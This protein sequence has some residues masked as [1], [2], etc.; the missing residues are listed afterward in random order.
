MADVDT[1]MNVG[2]TLVIPGETCDPDSTTCVLTN[3]SAINTCVMGGPRLYYTIKG[4]TYE[5]IALR[6]NL[7]VDTVADGANATAPLTVGEFVKLP[8]CGPSQCVIQ[9]YKFEYG[10]YKDLADEYGTTVGQLMS[11]SPGYNYSEWRL[12]GNNAPS[13]DLAI[14][15]TL[16]SDNITIY[17]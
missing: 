6:L 8:L 15:C 9:P 2:Q 11:L 1:P 4:D 13:I 16:L 10:T 3:T 14:N 7:T 5:R 12:S 17:S